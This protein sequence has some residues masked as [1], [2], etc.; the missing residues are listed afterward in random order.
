MIRGLVRTAL[1]GCAAL[2]LS[3][4][5]ANAGN[6]ALTGHDSDFHCFGAVASPCL[7][8][9]DMVA[10]ARAGSDDPTLPVLSFDQG[11]QLTADLTSLGI[12]FTNV[13]TV[14]G[15]GTADFDP[16]LYSAFVVASHTSCGGCDNSTAFVDAIADRLDD[17]TDFFNAGGG[18]VGFSGGHSYAGP[19]QYYSFVPETAGGI[20]SSPPSSGYTSSPCF[21]GVTTTAVNG[22]ATHNF[23]PEPGS[24]GVSSLYCVSE[25]LT[26][27]SPTDPN[28]NR[29][30]TLLLQGGLIVTDVITTS[31]GTTTDGVPEPVV[32]TLVGL[33]AIGAGLRRRRQAR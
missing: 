30:M 22:N 10:F 21:G 4:A 9:R 13:S 11:S 1:A 5:P 8:I 24:P 26:G 7:Q 25:R 27:V 31:T 18:V 15:V 33:G 14:A 29:A 32:L 12:P 17:I 19:G 20:I 2:V 6:I 28:F 23:F 3:A 16:D